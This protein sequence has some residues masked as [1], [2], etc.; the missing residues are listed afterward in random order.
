MAVAV[1]ARASNA[2]A[3]RTGFMAPSKSVVPSVVQ[4]EHPPR[5]R[6]VS[7]KVKL[8]RVLRVRS[9]QLVSLPQVSSC[10]ASIIGA[11]VHPGRSPGLCCSGSKLHLHPLQS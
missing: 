9:A 8:Q 6:V 1:H 4:G 2:L 5:L 3:A 11:L 10:L 7:N